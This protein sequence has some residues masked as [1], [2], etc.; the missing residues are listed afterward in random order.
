M[1]DSFPVLLLVS[2]SIFK[3]S[4]ANSDGRGGPRQMCPSTHTVNHCGA[5]RAAAGWGRASTPP[6]VAELFCCPVAAVCKAWHQKAHP[7]R[8]KEGRKMT[9]D[10][11]C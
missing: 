6:A 3:S 2:P 10:K 7:G 8:K 4:P 11:N 1:V 5:G 9:S